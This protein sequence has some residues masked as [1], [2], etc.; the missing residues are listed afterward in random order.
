MVGSP[1]GGGR[2]ECVHE[3]AADR[4]QQDGDTSRSTAIRGSCAPEAPR[5]GPALEHD[6][7]R[8]RDQVEDRGADRDAWGQSTNTTPSVARAG[9]SDARRRAP[10]SSP[11]H[12]RPATPTPA[13]PAAQVTARPTRRGPRCRSMAASSAHPPKRGSKLSA[14]GASDPSTGLRGEGL[15]QPPSA[16]H[17]RVRSSSRSH[18]C[19]RRPPV[20]RH[21]GERRPSH[22]RRRHRA[23]W[24]PAPM[25][26]ARP[27]PPLPADAVRATPGRARPR[28]P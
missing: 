19:R 17:Y 10:A 8:P 20:D 22:R 13:R 21:E 6:R 3:E 1:G 23:A 9:L 14:A 5:A 28:P 7:G 26:G 18:G 16:P 15:V 2:S 24:E 25:P 11:A 27:T 4:G 12:A